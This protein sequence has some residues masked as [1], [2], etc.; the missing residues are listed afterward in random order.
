[1]LQRKDHMP[2]ITLFCI[3]ELQHKWSPSYNTR[4]SRQKVSVTQHSAT[5]IQLSPSGNF[6]Q[7]FNYKAMTFDH[8]YTHDQPYHNPNPA[9]PNSNPTVSTNPALLTL[10][11]T[12][13]PQTLTPLL[14]S[15]YAMQIEFHWFF[16]FMMLCGRLRWLLVCFWAHINIIYH[17][18]II[19]YRTAGC[20]NRH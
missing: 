10:T 18:C 4:S 7:H 3:D 20:M 9:Y 12:I 6:T 13:V 15:R 1:M 11:L 17:I 19:S 8:C 14:M 16:K 5:L 2:C